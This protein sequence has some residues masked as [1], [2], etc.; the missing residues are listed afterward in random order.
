MKDAYWEQRGAEGFEYRGE[1]FYTITP[2]G[3][4][5]ERRRKLLNSFGACSSRPPRG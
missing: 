4:Y 3:F 2:I 1:T 5:Y